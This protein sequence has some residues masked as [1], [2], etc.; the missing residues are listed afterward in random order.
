MERIEREKLEPT[1]GEVSKRLMQEGWQM[2]EV[3]EHLYL[4]ADDT[5]K[6]NVKSL[7]ELGELSPKQTSQLPAIVEACGGSELDCYRGGVD[8][9][10]KVRNIIKGFRCGNAPYSHGIDPMLLA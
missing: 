4:L 9:A 1:L 10:Q 2:T 5:N 8:C 3:Q 6:W 7:R